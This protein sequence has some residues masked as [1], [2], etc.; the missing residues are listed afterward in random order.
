MVLIRDVGRFLSRLLSANLAIVLQVPSL[1]RLSTIAGELGLD[2]E[3]DELAEHRRVFHKSKLETN[4]SLLLSLFC[5]FL[6][7]VMEN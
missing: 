3:K 4:Y 7:I 5:F 1:Q 6:D 2:F